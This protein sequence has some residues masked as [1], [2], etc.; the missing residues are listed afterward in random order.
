LTTNVRKNLS[1]MRAALIAETGRGPLSAQGMAEQGM[2]NRILDRTQTTLWQDL[3]PLSS[4]VVR[5]MPLQAGQRYYDFPTDLDIESAT[6][7]R[8][9]HGAIWIECE[10]GLEAYHYNAFNSDAGVRSSPA[11]RWDLVNTGSNA[12]G[13]LG[14]AQVEIW[15]I[16]AQNGMARLEGIMTPPTLVNDSDQ[17]VIDP[18]LIICTAAA[19]LMARDKQDG[20]DVMNSIA[21]AKLKQAKAS[22]AR[23]QRSGP[24]I[25]GVGDSM[26][27]PLRPRQIVAVS[28]TPAT[29]PGST[30]GS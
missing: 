4:R 3:R 12:Q 16:P 22:R 29:G 11:M 10:R 17:C 15:P 28:T 26:R 20:A 6:D 5:F 30:S 25:P 24:V 18:D 8:T 23:I 7:F 2:L 27:N 9:Q 1:Q 13:A 21:Q 14:D 19:E